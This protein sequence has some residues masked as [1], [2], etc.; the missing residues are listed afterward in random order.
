MAW[1]TVRV[2]FKPISVVLYEHN[3]EGFSDALAREKHLRERVGDAVRAEMARAG[4]ATHIPSASPTVACSPI[5]FTMEL[6]RET[7]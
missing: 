2:T 5:T 7:K 4:G 6:E 3:G 1:I